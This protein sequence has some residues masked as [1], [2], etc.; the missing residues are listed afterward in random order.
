MKISQ[1]QRLKALVQS[2]KKDYPTSERGKQNLYNVLKKQIL[3]KIRLIEEG[4][5]NEVKFARDIEEYCVRSDKSLGINFRPPDEV[6]EITKEVGGI[7]IEK[8]TKPQAK[9]DVVAE[10][11]PKVST[12]VPVKKSPLIPEAKDIKDDKSTEEGKPSPKSISP[13]S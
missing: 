13:S 3:E 6:A 12:E 5:L 8:D 7:V 2:H 10:E 1:I 4:R 9:I 11:K